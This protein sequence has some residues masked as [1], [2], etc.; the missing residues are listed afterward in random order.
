MSNVQ[1]FKVSYDDQLE[2]SGYKAI[3]AANELLKEYGL[4]LIIEDD[5]LPHDGFMIYNVTLREIQ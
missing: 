5:N 1:I 2:D 3:S 4:R